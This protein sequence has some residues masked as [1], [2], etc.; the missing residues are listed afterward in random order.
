MTATSKR[1]RSRFRPRPDAAGSVGARALICTENSRRRPSARCTRS[2][3]VRAPAR[4][5]PSPSIAAKLTV[6][7]RPSDTLSLD[8]KLYARSIAV[9]SSGNLYV[10]YFDTSTGANPGSPTPGT[11]SRS[12]RRVRPA[13]NRWRVTKA[14]RTRRSIRSLLRSIHPGGSSRTVQPTLTATAAMTR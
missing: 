10:G 11:R 2:I 8:S 5:R 7:P 13:R 6:T 12:M 14:S 9:D 3:S 4:V 1:L